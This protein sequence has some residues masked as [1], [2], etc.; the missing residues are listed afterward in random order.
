MVKSIKPGVYIN[1]GQ[2]EVCHEYYP[3]HWQYFGPYLQPINYL[4]ME[5]LKQGNGET[6][7]IEIKDDDKTTPVLVIG[8]LVK[9]W[10]EFEYEDDNIHHWYY[11][12]YKILEVK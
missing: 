4:D 1:R 2:S 9:S 5:N 7:E 3:N 12:E 11:E 10:E 6:K 8:E